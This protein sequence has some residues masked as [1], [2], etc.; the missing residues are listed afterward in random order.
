M[1]RGKRLIAN[2]TILIRRIVAL[3][4]IAIG[5]MFSY[6]IVV[7][8]SV[9]REKTLMHESTASAKIPHPE[10]VSTINLSSEGRQ[11]NVMS[12]TFDPSG[13]YLALLCTTYGTP[14][15]II[16]IWDLK[17]NRKQV[18]IEDLGQDWAVG[19]DDN[20]KWTPDGKFITFG[21]GG[22][23]HPIKFWDSL[24]GKMTEVAPAGAAADTLAFNRNGSKALASIVN[25]DGGIR[26]RLLAS[27][28]IRIYDT[29][30]WQSREFNT[31]P[32]QVQAV[33]WTVEGKILAVGIWNSRTYERMM[34]ADSH[35]LKQDFQGLDIQAL[36]YDDEL[37]QLID[38]SGRQPTLTKLLAPAIPHIDNVK[39]KD[40]TWYD[41]PALLPS[42]PFLKSDASGSIFAF[43]VNQIIDG[44]TLK[45]LTYGSSANN[46][47]EAV[48]IALTSRNIVLSPDGNY[49]YWTTGS[50]EKGGAENFV[51]DTRTGKPL[52]WFKDGYWGI[53]IRSDGKL[54][55][56]GNRSSV[57]LFSIQ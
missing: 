48:R 49:L 36:H 9:S 51:M 7:A 38:P 54:L 1:I 20:L 52:S 2:R 33:G 3:A 50:S 25:Y 18:R 57:E 39:G 8:A 16:I 35:A 12:L 40:H 10:K 34:A 53:A 29:T 15:N 41:S 32:F 23:V 46:D 28:H 17:E 26:N 44:R 4:T 5:T 11:I 30:T 42:G 14:Y 24:T 45:V 55:A 56:L 6:S 37:G 19:S 13:R 21:T 47:G 31:G 27:S 22:R 43:G